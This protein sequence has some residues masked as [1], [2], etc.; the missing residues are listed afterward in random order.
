MMEKT[1]AK[2]LDQPGDHPTTM[3]TGEARVVH[4]MEIRSQADR[5]EA[6]ARRV[7]SAGGLVPG[8]A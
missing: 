6:I 2:P 7:A 5:A 3:G 8:R 4:D 1:N